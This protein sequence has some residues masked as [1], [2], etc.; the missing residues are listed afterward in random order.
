VINHAIHYVHGV[1]TI[2]LQPPI[3]FSFA[4]SEE[5]PKWKRHFEQYCEASGLVE[6]G[7]LRQVSTLLYCLGEEA[8]EVLDTTCISED[9]RKKYQKVIDEFDKWRKMWYMSALGLIRVTSFW[10]SQQTIL[11]RYTD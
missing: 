7:E 10:M 11:L 1:R 5:W 8:E 6:K 2:N 4:K 9:D 3:A